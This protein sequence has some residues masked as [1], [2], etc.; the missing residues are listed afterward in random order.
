VEQTRRPKRQARPACDRLDRRDVP[1]TFTSPMVPVGFPSIVSIPAASFAT[2]VG[3]SAGVSTSGQVGML[4]FTNTPAG[5]VGFNASSINPTGVGTS[6]ATAST[7]SVTTPSAVSTSTSQVGS[8]AAGRLGTTATL[9]PNA[10]STA[11]SPAAVAARG[12][13]V[14]GGVPRFRAGVR[15][16]P[17][18]PASLRATIAPGPLP[19][20]AM[21]VGAGVNTGPIGTR[22]LIHLAPNVRLLH[23]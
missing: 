11:A 21:Q 4:S 5:P 16:T 15:F 13:A 9:R 12:A 22:G 8:N 23:R 1:A 19:L 18:T 2:G 17:V 3:T 7:G 10:T 14:L 6:L 20:F